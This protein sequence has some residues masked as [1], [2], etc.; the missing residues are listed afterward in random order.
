MSC[1]SLDDLLLDPKFRLVKKTS[2]TLAGIAELNGIE[3][4]IK[5]V[6]NDSWLKGSIARVS[7][8]RA[9]KALRGGTILQRAGFAHPR[10]IAAL[11]QHRGASVHASYVILEYLR[12]P[13]T[14]S[15]FALADGRDFNWRCRL[16]KHVADA[17]SALHAAGCYTR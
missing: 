2:R 16:S 8:S 13:K 6:T 7:G 3:V 15:R 1:E 10:L 12:R 14:L 5:R 4:F 11:E 17:I 9:R